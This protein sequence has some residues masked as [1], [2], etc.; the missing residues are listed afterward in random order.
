[1][2]K[3]GFCP[4][5]NV[6]CRMLLGLPDEW[7]YRNPKCHLLLV[8]IILDPLPQKRRK[9]AHWLWKPRAVLP[10][11]GCGCL[12]IVLTVFPGADIL[13]LAR[14]TYNSNQFEN[15]SYCMHDL[16]FSKNGLDVVRFLTTRFS[17]INNFFLMVHS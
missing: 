5:E 1:M 10:C 9:A 14:I 17:W 7:S 4:E 2:Y 6:L 13:P 8:R 3:E 11:S 15:F 12:E 16:Q